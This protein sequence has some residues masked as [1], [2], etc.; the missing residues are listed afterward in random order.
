MDKGPQESSI[1][2]SSF[3][4]RHQSFVISEKSLACDEIGYTW[5]GCRHHDHFWDPELTSRQG[6]V[7][8][9]RLVDESQSGGGPAGNGIG[10]ACC[11][12]LRDLVEN[13]CNCKLSPCKSLVQQVHACIEVW[14]WT[15][16]G[17]GRDFDLE[18]RWVCGYG[19]LDLRRRR[20]ALGEDSPMKLELQETRKL[21]TSNIPYIAL[22]YCWGGKDPA[23]TLRSNHQ[24]RVRGMSVATLPRTYRQAVYLAR[25]LGISHL[26]IDALCIVQDDD[27]DW[28]RESSRMAEVY[29]GAYLVFV[30]AAAADVEGGLDPPADVKNWRHLTAHQVTA[31]PILVRAKNHRRDACALLPISTRAWTYQERLVAKRCLIFCES[32][33]VWECLQGCRC[34]CSAAHTVTRQSDPQLLPSVL[35]S[36]TTGK[37][38]ASSQDA[39]KFWSYAVTT[40]SKMRL[41][42]PTDRLPAISA[43]ASVIQAETGDQYLAGL[44]RRGLLKQL[45]WR[46]IRGGTLNPPY[47]VY[48][49]PSWSWASY[50]DAVEIPVAGEPEDSCAE[51]AEILHVHCEP[52]NLFS[53][54]GA[55]HQGTL[56]LRGLCMWANVQHPHISAE[57]YVEKI[58]IIGTKLEFPVRLQLDYRDKTGDPIRN[59]PRRPDL[60]HAMSKAAAEKR[61]APQRP[62]QLLYLTGNIFLVLSKSRCKYGARIRVGT[63][64]LDFD[65]VDHDKNYQRVNVDRYRVRKHLLS[66]ASRE[67]VVVI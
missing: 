27:E 58:S 26:W 56:T 63:L 55:V 29:S 64:S 12:M 37:R 1:S 32:E 3:A 46:H 18:A 30:A 6:V 34:Q 22:S 16:G 39:Y 49:A 5:R 14:I 25:Q 35:P 7:S 45:A 13:I 8:Y 50:P 23:K 48:V 11:R 62:V 67:E 4:E 52:V 47:D 24:D 66:V 38:F 65:L 10:C 17:D 9:Q 21:P 40:F 36:G 44:W 28:Q 51:A 41:T 42:R 15:Y 19:Y 20:L 33:V 59:L 2:A 43:I 31:G 57:M 61:K 53:P 60:A 54:F